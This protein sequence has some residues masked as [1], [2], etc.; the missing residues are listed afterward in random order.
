MI[1]RPTRSTRTDTLFPYTTLFRSLPY[2]RRDADPRFPESPDTSAAGAR[3]RIVGGHHYPAHARFDEQMA[4]CGSTG[5]IMEARFQCDIGIGP[6][7]QFA[8]LHVSHG[9]GVWASSRL[10][11]APG[12]HFPIADTDAEDLGFVTL[13]APAPF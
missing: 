1:R 6:A 10:C 11:P 5:R 2:A 12:C 4:A 8:R 9:F 3:I 7:C 13:A